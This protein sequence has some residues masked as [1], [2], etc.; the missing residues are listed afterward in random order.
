[1]A[2]KKFPQIKIKT[3]TGFRLIKKTDF[4]PAVHEIYVDEN[5]PE[6]RESSPPKEEDTKKLEK[7]L[8]EE[9]E[10]LAQAEAADVD[11]QLLAME[12]D[13]L[14][15][16]GES[17]SDDFIADPSMGH[18]NLVRQIMNIEA[19]IDTEEEA[20]EIAEENDGIEDIEIDEENG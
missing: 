14:I 5:R 15:S 8:A 16:Y 18:L 19:A 20:D 6:P 11:P 13:E 7:A 17:I 12:I 3:E 1:M 9:E 2:V 10:L 4:D